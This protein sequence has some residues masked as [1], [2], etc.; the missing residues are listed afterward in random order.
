[1]YINRRWCNEKDVGK[2]AVVLASDTYFGEE[3]SSKCTL[4]GRN[5]KGT[6][7]NALDANKL[8][9][10][11]STIH[12]DSAFSKLTKEEFSKESL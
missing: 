6:S 2:L 9:M 8:S 12:A 1:M 5:T 3:V 10:L 4:I 7:K 11:L